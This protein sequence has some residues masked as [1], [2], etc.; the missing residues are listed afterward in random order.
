MKT[1]VETRYRLDL[2]RKSAKVNVAMPLITRFLI[3]CTICVCAAIATAHDYDLILRGGRIVDGTGNPSFHADVAVKD[4]KIAEIG[5]ITG[6]GLRELDARKLV[7]APGFIDVHTHAEEVDELPLAENFL[8]MGVTTLVLGNCGSSTLNVAEYFAHLE[9]VTVSP[10]I[11]TLIGHGTVRSRAMRGSFLRPP[12]EAE[13]DEMKRLVGCAMD[14]GALGLSTGLIYAPGVFAKTDE[15]IELAKVAAAADGIYATHQ[16]SEAAKIF[17]SLEE[18]FTIARA[19]GIRAQISHLKLSG[20]ANWGKAEKVLETIERARAEGLDLTQDQY[21]YT[22]SSTG[23][24]QLIP[25]RIKEGGRAKLLERL[26]EIETKG[27]IITE[28]KE[29]LIERQ[30]PDYGYV[31]I[32]AHKADPSLNGL[33]LPE[34][35]KQRRGS[36]LLDEQIELIFEIERNG[37][38]SAVF[39]GMSDGDLET[40]A[41]HP[42]TMFASDSG[43][44]R[45]QIDVP[46]PRGYGNQARVLG[47]YVREK[48]VLRLEDAIRRMTSLPAQTFRLELRGEVR[49]GHW[50]DLVVFDPETVIDHATYKDPHHYATGCKYVLVNGVLVIENDAHTGA[51]PGKTVRHPRVTGAAIGAAATASP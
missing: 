40:F 11:A 17:E 33:T 3:A 29:K 46:H 36:D 4:G 45:F 30:S 44:R 35:A 20:P 34:A 31:T 10:N 27:A 2:I 15:I 8:R 47:R 14:E 38:A 42:N 9:R 51:R 21:V 24:S 39:H 18:I 48:K 49:A 37:G 13:L 22:A 5:R 12:T 23:L 28:M 16:R 19:A 25:D 50:A 32:A 6:A 7:V 26:E 41:R 43:V 1:N